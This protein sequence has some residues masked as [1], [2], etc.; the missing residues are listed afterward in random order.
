[1]IYDVDLLML[2]IRATSGLKLDKKSIGLMAVFGLGIHTCL[3]K[4]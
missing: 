1:M 2:P 4:S 3:L